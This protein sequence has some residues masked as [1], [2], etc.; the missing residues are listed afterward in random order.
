MK[1]T[2]ERDAQSPH[3]IHET[4]H[5]CMRGHNCFFDDS[6]GKD[7]LMKFPA[8][9]FPDFTTS[10]SRSSRS[11]AA[12]GPLPIF[13]TFLPFICH[14]RTSVLTLRIGVIHVCRRRAK[15]SWWKCL[16]RVYSTNI[17]CAQAARTGD[18]NI[19]SVVL[20]EYDIPKRIVIVFSVVR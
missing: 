5:E 6:L 15:S 17:R 2:I 1:M 14:M 12:T 13:P 18:L 4:N 9:N 20:H 7:P 3:S 8:P 10:S 11:T 16:S 19:A